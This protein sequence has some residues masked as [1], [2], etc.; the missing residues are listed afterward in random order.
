MSK[1]DTTPI[2]QCGK[3]VVDFNV[4]SRWSVVAGTAPD[5]AIT[6]AIDSFYEGGKA[7]RFSCSGSGY[8]ACDYTRPLSI[9]L[10]DVDT[11]SLWVDWTMGST[12]SAIVFYISSDEFTNYKSATIFPNIDVGNIRADGGKYCYTFR[13]EH[14]I[15]SGGTIDWT[16]ITKIRFRITAASGP[17]SLVI[18]ALYCGKTCRPMV[19][20]TFDDSVQSTY[21]DMVSRAA[22]AHALDIPI[23]HY[24]ITTSLNYQDRLTTQQLRDLQA[25][26]DLIAGHSNGGPGY[27]YPNSGYTAQQ[28]ADDMDAHLEWLRTNGF[29]GYEYFSWPGGGYQISGGVS[30]IETARARTKLS[31]SISGVCQSNNRVEKV[32]LGIIEPMIINSAPLSAGLALSKTYIDKAIQQGTLV[33]FYVHK[34]STG[35]ATPTGTEMTG[36][37]WAALLAYIAERRDAGLIDAVTMQDVYERTRPQGSIQVVFEVES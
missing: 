34:I 36:N 17:E 4:L 26:G 23:T 20:L 2:I 7:M 6:E 21:F 24:T 13:K 35:A 16:K 28:V 5:R 14:L 22:E 31:R 25:A 18:G 30:Y 10:S 32:Q 9:D 12:S 33:T 27:S 29:N 37:D 15:T 3:K 8:M 1:I 19:A 11:F